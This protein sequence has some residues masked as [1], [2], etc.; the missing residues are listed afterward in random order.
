[1][2]G[3]QRKLVHA[4][5]RDSEGQ[6]T[7]ALLGIIFLPGTL[8]ASVFSMTFFN[9]QTD[10]DSTDMVAPTFWIYWAI[11]IP[12]TF[13]IMGIF[14]FWTRHRTRKYIEEDIK[15]ERSVEDMEIQ[16]QSAMRKRTMN[17]VATWTKQN[18][19]E[20]NGGGD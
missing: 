8:L 13:L 2:A 15:L 5:K 18:G 1:M 17:K 16:I 4:A 7:I 20:K 12:T 9:F 10:P 19:G 11:T 14:Y 3:E 6:R